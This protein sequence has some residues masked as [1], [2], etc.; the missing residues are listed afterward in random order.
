MYLHNV[1]DQRIFKHPVK[2]DALIIQNILNT[3]KDKAAFSVL[4]K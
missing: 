1:I 3:N 4:G 2:C